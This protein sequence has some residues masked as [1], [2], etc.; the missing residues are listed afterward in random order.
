MYKIYIENPSGA[1]KLVKSANAGLWNC[2]NLG[3]PDGVI[4]TTATPEKWNYLQE[5]GGG[6]PGYKIVLTYTP[7]ANTT[8]DISDAVAIIPVR[9]NGQSQTLGHNGGG[10][11][12]FGNDN[13]TS[14]LAGSDSAFVANIEA[15]VW[16]VRA[17]EGVYFSVGG[18]KVFMSLEDNA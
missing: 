7:S 17:N 11:G 8:L 15:N 9:I 3:S 18:D 10:G 4:S 16:V 6:K 2:A 1:R 13:F 14:V 5:V 12:G